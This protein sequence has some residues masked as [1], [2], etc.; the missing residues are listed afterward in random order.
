MDD[1]IEL[2]TGYLPPDSG[3]SQE[4]VVGEV[5]RIVEEK[6]GYNFTRPA[7]LIVP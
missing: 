2:I 6:A 1:I 5:I 3:I 7:R 4:A